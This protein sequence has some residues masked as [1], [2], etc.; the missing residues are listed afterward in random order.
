MNYILHFSFKKYKR[1]GDQL[2]MPISDFKTKVLK[3][4]FWCYSCLVTW[5]VSMAGAPPGVLEWRIHDLP[6]GLTRYNTNVHCD[7]KNSLYQTKQLNNG[8]Y[9]IVPN[10]HF[11]REP[12]ENM[13]MLFAH[14]KSNW[15]A[16]VTRYI[17]FFSLKIPLMFAG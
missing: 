8:L 12:S 14:L 5:H 10:Y 9:Y 1:Y 3:A 13:C 11:S 7:L 4:H 6:Y 2:L 16:N 15:V 17:S